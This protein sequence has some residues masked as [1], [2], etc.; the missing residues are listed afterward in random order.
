M[1]SWWRLLPQL[2]RSAAWRTFWTAGRSRPMRMAM[3][4]ITTSSSISVKPHLRG[5]GG[6]G[7]MGFF[8]WLRLRAQ[9]RALWGSLAQKAGV[10]AEMRV[11]IDEK[12]MRT[13][14]GRE[15]GRRLGD[16][17]TGFA[18]QIPEAGPPTSGGPRRLGGW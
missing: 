6:A 4:A 14:A 11:R 17:G 15:A 8:G 5:L 12:S 2:A 7:V 3:M 13:G 10:D 16:H 1:A 9:L 18:E